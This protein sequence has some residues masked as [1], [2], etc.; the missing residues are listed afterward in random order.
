M[1][2][3]TSVLIAVLC[4]N[5]KLYIMQELAKEELQLQHCRPSPSNALL[6][7]NF[8]ADRCW[9]QSCL[10]KFY[11]N[12]SKQCYLTTV[13]Q[14]LWNTTCI[15]VVLPHYQIRFRIIVLIELLLVGSTVHN[16]LHFSYILHSDHMFYVHRGS[17]MLPNRNNA[18][19]QTVHL[20][21][22]EFYRKIKRKIVTIKWPLNVSSLFLLENSTWDPTQFIL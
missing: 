9:L 5:L 14:A 7:E 16:E 22:F 11:G 3:Y 6:P 18:E 4:L 19:D 15:P 13:Y 17:S 12:P 8:R 1:T 20:W 21:N 2:F 10:A